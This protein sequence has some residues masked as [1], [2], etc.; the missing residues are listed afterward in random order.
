MK[1]SILSAAVALLVG[2]TAFA[3]TASTLRVYINPGHGSWTSNDRPNRTIGRKAYTSVGTDTTGFFESN[4]NLQKGF[5]CLERLRDMGLKFDTSLN[6]TSTRYTTGAAKSMSNNIVMSRVKNGPYE[7]TNSTSSSN[8]M[9]YNRSLSVIA[10]EV[11]S[12]NFDMFISI[13]SDAATE[14]TKTNFPTILYRGTDASN[15]VAGSKAVATSCW[16]RHF[17]NNVH[18]PWSSTSTRIRGDISF[19]NS[20]STYGYLGVLKHNVRGFLVEGYFHTYQ[21]SRQRAMNWDVDRM[22]GIEYARGI[23]DY[24][25]INSETTGDIYGIVRADGVYFSQDLYTPNTSSSDVYLPLNGVKVTLKNSAGTTLKTYTTDKEYNGAFAFYK[26]TPGTYTVECNLDGYATTTTTVTVTKGKTACPKVFMKE[27]QP[28][29]AFTR[30]QLWG[31]STG[32]TIAGN[33]VEFVCD[34][35]GAD[36]TTL[37][38]STEQGDYSSK[39]FTGTANWELQPSNSAHLSYTLPVSMFPNGHYYWR[40]KTSKDGYYDTY[41]YEANFIVENSLDFANDYNH[42]RDAAEYPSFTAANGDKLKLTN[43]W[44]R[45]DVHGNGLGHAY[46]EDA[47]ANNLN[48]DFAVLGPEYAGGN[49]IVYITNTDVISSDTSDHKVFLERYDALTGETLAPLNLTFDDDYYRGVYTPLNGVTVDD[50]GHLL[51][52][53]IKVTADDALSVAVVDVNTGKCRTIMTKKYEAVKRIDA[54][55]VVGD[56]VDGDGFIYAGVCGTN[57]VWRWAVTAGKVTPYAGGGH[58]LNN[59][60][61]GYNRVNVFNGDYLIVDDQSHTPEIYMQSDTSGNPT[62][63]F[64]QASSL[65]GS[66]QMSG[67]N[68][69]EMKGT[70]FFV[71]CCTDWVDGFK[72][73]LTT[74]SGLPAS[75]TGLKSLAV[76]PSNSTG[77]GWR[78]PKSVIIADAEFLKINESTTRIYMYIP[79]NGLA[80]YEVTEPR[81]ALLT[82]SDVIPVELEEVQVIVSPEVINFSD[83]VDSAVIYTIGGQ[84][85]KAKTKS[86]FIER[87]AQPGVYVLRLTHNGVAQTHKL[88]IK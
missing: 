12:N 46:E 6:Q 59:H 10:S 30:A 31:P 84:T 81:T 20:S 22:E 77:M 70:T 21:P 37:E 1:R 33:C 39:F 26:L 27:G 86:S 69:F 66:T 7:S 25:G 14:G 34:N 28:K 51:V 9:L 85:V 2:G 60:T 41:S 76:F 47:D 88:I 73:R 54:I 63:T 64:S 71:Y 68:M 79:M 38:I 45:T 57:N 65:A 44:M 72:F 52:H 87:P 16:A 56:V 62:G 24:F 36:V 8:Y 35:T 32:K 49:G 17:T 58:Y 80:C 3:Y 67:G 40:V 18:Q 5:G 11:N 82:N 19:Y 29:T 78:M 75:L 13:H 4:T 83:D 50:A 48:R 55:D 74:G 43:L 23:A 61:L 53:N 42:C 15:N